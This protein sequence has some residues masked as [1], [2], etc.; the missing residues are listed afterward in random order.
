ML[1]MNTSGHRLE[2][3]A[4]PE[5]TLSRLSY[6]LQAALAW[7]AGQG[8]HRVTMSR[9]RGDDGTCKIAVTSDLPPS[10]D[11]YS[12]ITFIPELARMGLLPRRIADRD[13][14]TVNGSSATL[15]HPEGLHQTLTL[16]DIAFGVADMIV[17]MFRC[18][19]TTIRWQLAQSEMQL[20]AAP[21]LWP[22]E[23]QE[24]SKSESDNDPLAAVDSLPG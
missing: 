24:I 7:F 3:T 13:R 1:S 20:W 4:S 19:V 21:G 18:R 9:Q 2:I 15:V 11:M 17:F 6:A 23:L 10:L 14:W 12:G 22:S 5:V 16:G 8:M